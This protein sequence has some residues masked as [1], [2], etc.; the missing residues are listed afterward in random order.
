MLQQMRGVSG[1]KAIFVISSGIDTFSKMS[2]E[3]LLTTL[4]DANTPIYMIGIGQVIRQANPIGESAGPSVKIDWK[5]LED[6]LIAIAKASGGRAYFPENT[7]DLTSI[8]DDV[9]ENLRVRYVVTY[10]TSATDTQSPRLVRVELINPKTGGPLEIVDAGGKI[11]RASVALQSSYIPSSVS[12]DAV[13]TST[14]KG[15]P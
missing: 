2:Y 15:H 14:E 12:R 4:K 1:R 6:Q 13:N 3:D 9:M 11:I 5:G 8:Y 7:F 10:K